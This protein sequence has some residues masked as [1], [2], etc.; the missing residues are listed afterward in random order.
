MASLPKTPSPSLYLLK[1]PHPCNPFSQKGPPYF[2]FCKQTLP[3]YKIFTTKSLPLSRMLQN[4]SR[5]PNKPFLFLEIIIE[6]P[7]N[8][9]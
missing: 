4:I 2:P 3:P 9:V 1:N 5:I 8:L 6:T 7:R